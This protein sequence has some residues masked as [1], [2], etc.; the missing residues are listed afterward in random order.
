MYDKLAIGLEIALFSTIPQAAACLYFALAFWGIQTDRHWLTI[1]KNAVG[2]AVMFATLLLLPEVFRPMSLIGY[3]VLLFVLFRAHPWMDRILLVGTLSVLYNLVEV[4]MAYATI[5]LGL[6]EREGLTTDPRAIIPYI[7]LGNAFIAMAGALLRRFRWAPGKSIRL[8]FGQMHNRPLFGLVLLFIGNVMISA[9]LFYYVMQAHPFAASYMMFAT[10]IVSILIL[11]LTI[12]SITTLKNREILN[13]HE[14]YAEEIGNLFTTIR[15]Q[16][17]DFLNH[18]Q[19]I[20][21]FVRKRKI[22]ELERYVS[23]LVGEIVEI[24]D[25]IQIGH[26]ALAALIKSKMV[27]AVDRKID[28]RYSFEGMDRIG[29]G[30]ASVDYV[31][32]AGN[33]LDNALDE[34]L[35]RPQEERW[36]EIAGW[37]DESNVYL[38]VSNP[39]TIVTEE[40]RANMFRPGF[41]TKTDGGHT[42]LGLSIVKERVVH[43]RG[44]LDVQT[45]GDSVLSFRVRLPLRLQSMTS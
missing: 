8:F 43:Y 1:G 40:Q 9:V 3:G 31:K 28:F 33:L 45:V 27:F 10:S 36:V 2:T 13:T 38:T 11:L 24:N 17:H 29:V 21:A 22:D 14:T 7:V 32:I 16:R 19:V 4:S 42:G 12:R 26:P 15:G 20:Q 23:E 34:V 44:E 18:V 39:V 6:V 35:Q 37:T 41:T 30:I 25:L 5:T